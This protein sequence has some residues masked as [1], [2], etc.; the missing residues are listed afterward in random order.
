MNTWL[1]FN[2]KVHMYMYT[3]KMNMQDARN[4]SVYLNIGI[5]LMEHGE[6]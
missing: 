6:Q 3:Y 1:A 5:C 2:A 4:Y